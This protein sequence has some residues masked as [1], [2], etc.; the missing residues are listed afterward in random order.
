MVVT[1][2]L[3]HYFTPHIVHCFSVVS[4]TSQFNHSTRVDVGDVHWGPG[5]V[6]RDPLRGPVLQGKC[7]S[8]LHIPEVCALDIQK[9]EKEVTAATE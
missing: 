1:D 7:Q 9:G 2:R 3:T 8:P 4:L 5:T 6:V